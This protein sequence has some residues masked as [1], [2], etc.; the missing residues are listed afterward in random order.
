MNWN[1]SS[2]KDNFNCFKKKK[3]SCLDTVFLK[4]LTKRAKLTLNLVLAILG[5]LLINKT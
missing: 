1:K 2:L 5:R 3:F 4:I